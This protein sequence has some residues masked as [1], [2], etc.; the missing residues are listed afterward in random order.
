MKKPEK[1]AFKDYFVDLEKVNPI[2]NSKVPDMEGQY[3]PGTYKRTYYDADQFGGNV[4]KVDAVD[5]PVHLDDGRLKPGRADFVVEKKVVSKKDQLD[6]AENEKWEGEQT[7]IE[8]Q[9]ESGGVLEFETPKWFR[10]LSELKDRIQ[11]AV[12]MTDAINSGNKLT[13]SDTTPNGKIL[14]AMR[15]KI[16]ALIKADKRPN[17]TD[18]GKKVVE[19]P[20]ALDTKHLK[21]LNRRGERLLVEIVDPDWNAKIQT[22]EGIRL[23]EYG[24]LQKEHEGAAVEG[25]HRRNMEAMFT[26]GGYGDAI[27]DDGRYDSLKGFLQLIATYIYRGQV[28]DLTGKPS[29][30]GFSLMAR[31]DFA[32]MY[33][34]S[35]TIPEQ[36]LFKEMVVNLEK[37]IL[38][39]E[40]QTAIH[41]GRNN[42]IGYL[43]AKI[44]DKREE[45]KTVTGAKKAKIT[46]QIKE[47]RAERRRQRKALKVNLEGES[48]FY[49]SGHASVNPTIA[50]W[51]NS[52]WKQGEA[53][54]KT[55][56]NRKKMDASNS[57][58]KDLLSNKKGQSAA[59][60]ARTVSSEYGDKDYHLAEF[61]VRGSNAPWLREKGTERKGNSKIPASDWVTFVEQR[62]ESAQIRSADT[63][64]DPRT[65]ENEAANTGLKV[66]R[67]KIKED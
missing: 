23:S 56:N 62:F 6:I 38:T 54:I 41:K 34:Y 26:T 5:L 20:A 39:D 47:F 24:S 3:N 61:E 66:G 12:T 43:G 13:E 30:Y 58:R 36:N 27:A 1:I 14:R 65:A 42:R 4:L 11:D 48:H 53:Q 59:M 8:I 21:N 46:E 67:T 45:L 29:K 28:R 9:S 35:L 17:I 15:A 40:L 18:L 51:L 50:D 64:D 44:A 25:M 55:K 63:P 57:K 16:P 49:Y 33:R 37:K 22:S 52:I 2:D 7:A 19:W 32:S 60:G 31:S 10:D